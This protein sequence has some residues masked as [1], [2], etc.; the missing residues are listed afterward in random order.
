NN[1]I[2]DECDIA[3]GTSRDCNTNSVP[4]ECD[5]DDEYSED[6]NDNGI[7]DECDLIGGTSHDCNANGLPDECELAGVL[8]DLDFNSG[9]DS[10]GN[11]QGDLVFNGSG[12]FQVTFTDDDSS[13]SNGG[14]AG[15]VHISNINYGNIKVGTGDLVLGAFNSF[16]GP[17]NY[18]SSGIV[19]HFSHGVE[20]VQLDDTDDDGTLKTLFA[21]DEGGALIGQTAAGSQI[22]FQIDISMT[23][24]TLIHSVEFDTQAGSAGGSYDGTVFTIDNFHVEGASGRRVLMV[25]VHGSSYDA[26]GYS[27]YQTLVQAGAEATYVNLSSHGQVANL[28]AANRYDQI[29]VFDLSSGTDS[30]PTDWQAIGDWFN[31]DPSRVV[32][33]DSRMIS[34]YWN[35]RCTNEGQNLTEN[36]YE[37]MKIRGGGLLLGTDHDVF[38]SGIN[39]INAH[40]GLQPFVGNFS[41]TYIPVDVG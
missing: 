41:L 4:D 26:D 34:S 33:C 10:L 22:T 35:G 40:I 8:I 14:N 2:P 32:I 39:S 25:N 30:Y 28:L 29:W 5:V 16:D 1:S 31:T 36:Y 15:G 17:N 24:G 21:F 12:A 37:N 27:I 9:V 13:G 11:S 18:H 7:P 20:L 3:A 6:C 19:A 23:G 38:Q